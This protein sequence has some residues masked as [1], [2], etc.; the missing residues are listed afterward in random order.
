MCATGYGIRRSK[1]LRAEIG[2]FPVSTNERK[3][4]S[5]K[6]NFKRVALVAVAALGLGVL[7]SVAPASATTGITVAANGATAT[8]SRGIVTGVATAQ[9]GTTN[10]MSM[11][12]TGSLYVTAGAHGAGTNSLLVA[13]GTI[14][15]CAGGTVTLNSTATQCTNASDVDITATVV[16]TA[17]ATLVVLSQLNSGL[18]AEATRVTISIVAASTVG[19]F[20]A[21]KSNIKATIAAGAFD[22]SFTVDNVDEKWETGSA[23]YYSDTYRA[24]ATTVLN[25]N[26][27]Y[28]TFLLKDANENGLSTSTTGLSVSATGGC[29]V[30]FASATNVLGTSA[31]AL[32]NA[33]QSSNTVYIKQAVANAPV[34]CVVSLSANGAVIATKTYTILGQVTKLVVSDEVIAKSGVTTE[35]AFFVDAQDAAGN[36]VPGV[37]VVNGGALTGSVDSITA[38]TASGRTTTNVYDGGVTMDVNC[39]AKGL[40][41]DLVVKTTNASAATINSSAFSIQCSGSPVN[42]SA[43][44]DKASYT[45]GEVAT[46]TITAKDSAGNLTW[47]GAELADSESDKT[48]STY[49]VSIAGGP[50]AQVGSIVSTDSFTSGVKKYK[51]TVGGVSSGSFQLVV[52]LPVYNSTTYSQSAVSVGYKVTTGADSGVQLADVLKA[53]VSLIASINKQIAALQKA[54]LKK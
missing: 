33:S 23:L 26:Y 34:K 6:T 42:Y 43:S 14:S 30:G 18:T 32:Y 2:K 39:A 25:G 17:G 21:S 19:A 47:D 46:L 20:S 38:N 53:I 13:G 49:A 54:L 29:L 36:S 8:T 35:D 11:L 10:T 40:A 15:S 31:S 24:S 52:D 48:A 45:I 44:L 28:L 22:S 9:T 3:N 37:T 51:F 7:T 16:P 1:D 5:T 4:M 41:K 12:P 50:M 27:G